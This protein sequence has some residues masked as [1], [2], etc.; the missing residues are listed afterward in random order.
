MQFTKKILVVFI[1]LLVLISTSGVFVMI[2]TCMSSRK[3]EISFTDEHKCCKSNKQ[4]GKLCSFEM[5]C[6]KVDFQY[7]KLNVVSTAP[8]KNNSTDLFVAPSFNYL[9]AFVNT[10][11][12]NK[13]TFFKPP[14]ISFNFSSQF[15]QLLI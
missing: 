3:S 9:S 15:L 4:K 11:N 10:G 2:H 7:H 5:K 14:L 12:F 8:E 1:A 6:C 13:P